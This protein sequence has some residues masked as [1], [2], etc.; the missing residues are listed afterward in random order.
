MTPLRQK[1]FK[2]EKSTRLN[3]ELIFLSERSTFNLQD[4]MTE[5]KISRSTA[6]RDITALESLGLAL[7]ANP[8]RQGGYHLIQ[9]N[10]L[11]PI[12]LGLDEINA[13]FFALKA[14]QIL[15]TNPFEQSYQRLA[16]R[17]MRTLTPKQQQAVNKMQQAVDYL[18]TPP[19]HSNPYLKDLLQAIIEHHLLQITLQKQPDQQLTLQPY[20]IF[21][22]HGNWFLS[23]YNLQTHKMWRYRCD[24]I[25]ACQVTAETGQLSTAELK[26]ALQALNQNHQQRFRCRLTQAGADAF[27]KNRYPDMQ[28]QKTNDQLYLEGGYNPNEYQYLLDYLLSFGDTI[29]VETPAKLRADYLNRLQK[30]L[31]R[32]Q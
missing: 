1:G 25:I 7:Y 3:Q 12:T 10:P 5:F 28:L 18:N 32:Y 13:I 15:A 6:L 31:T 20:Q 9:K 14:L 21:Y 16:Q 19:L 8:G 24:E 2:M 11:I 23:A 17:L 26:A 29:V 30:M 4:L 27:L 22:R